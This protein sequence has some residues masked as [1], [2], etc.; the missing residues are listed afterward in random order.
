MVHVRNPRL[1]GVERRVRAVEQHDRRR[2]ARSLVAQ[3]DGKAGLELHEAALRCPEIETIRVVA[4]SQQTLEAYRE[5]RDA[6]D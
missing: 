5:A 3:M 2:I 1:P 6:Q 4:F